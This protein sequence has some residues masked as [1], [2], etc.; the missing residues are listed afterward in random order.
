MRHHTFSEIRKCLPRSS[1]EGIIGTLIKKNVQYLRRHIGSICT[2]ST[3]GF[4]G[5]NSG[6]DIGIL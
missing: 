4:D 5:C 1:S 6:F 2:N 3:E